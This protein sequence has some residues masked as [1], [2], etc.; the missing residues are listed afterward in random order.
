MAKST[1]KAEAER[2]ELRDRPAADEQPTNRGFVGEETVKG[3]TRLRT[4]SAPG[5]YRITVGDDDPVAVQASSPSDAWAQYC[6]GK[7]SS[8]QIFRDSRR[9]SGA[10]ID[11]LA[12]RPAPEKATAK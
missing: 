2:L 8:K 5:L 12:E 9:H 11:L 7:R 10:L 3:K 1:K 6:D 4:R